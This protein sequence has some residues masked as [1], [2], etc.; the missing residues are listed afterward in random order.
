MVKVFYA[1]I[2]SLPIVL[3]SIVAVAELASSVRLMATPPRAAIASAATAQEPAMNIDL[4]WRKLPPIPD[5]EGFASP[6]AGTSGGALIVAGGANFPDKR[7]WEI[8]G[9]KHWYDSIFLLDQETGPWRIVGKLPHAGAYGI[10]VS[11]SA[12]VICAGG[13]DAQRHFQDVFELQWKD[14]HILRSELASLPRP[15]S[16]ASGALVGNT[17]YLEGGIDQPAAT[18]CLHT[19]WALDLAKPPARWQELPPCPGGERMLAVAGAAEGSFFL[20]SG[21]RLS[22]GPDGKP[23]REYLRDAWRYTPDRG[24]KR[25]A[26]LPRSAAAAAS[27]APLVA[28]SRLLVISGDDGKNVHFKPETQHPGFPHDVLAYDI[29]GD[30]WSAAGE[31][32]FSRGTVPT[33]TWHGDTVIPNGE[34]RPGYRSPEVWSLHA[35]V[36]H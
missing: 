3:I 19:F 34:A 28:D 33:T 20:F 17:F 21:V 14:G 6:F 24:W 23:L 18:T 4:Q 9:V 35:E 7:P 5:R 15:C 29:K 1:I 26:D 16:F 32:P 27:P 36:K 8:G 10:S 12:G 30:T 22:A 31:A 2:N 11:T 13:G 25:L